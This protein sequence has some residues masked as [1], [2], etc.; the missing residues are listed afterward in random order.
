MWK[1]SYKLEVRPIWKIP[2]KKKVFGTRGVDKYSLLFIA[3]N[4]P[5]LL[6]YPLHFCLKNRSKFR[7]GSCCILHSQSI[8]NIPMISLSVFLQ[9]FASQPHRHPS[10]NGPASTTKP[11]EAQLPKRPLRPWAQHSLDSTTT[12]KQVCNFLFAD[13][14]SKFMSNKT[15]G[16][17]E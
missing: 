15:C 16:K 9:M 5:L 1:W 17:L 6:L 12:G 7:T 2:L 3:S 13:I 4:A 10:S 8:C 14:P 11:S